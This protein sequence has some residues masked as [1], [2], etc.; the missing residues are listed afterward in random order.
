[1]P[2][3]QTNNDVY[4][5]AKQLRRNVV[6]GI[7]IV[8][9]IFTAVFAYNQHKNV[10][11]NQERLDNRMA[12]VK[13]VNAE[14]KKIE[15]AN[16]ELQKEVGIY[17]TLES[18][19]DFYNNFFN[20]SS[21]TQYRDNMK[22]LRLTYPNIDDD[23]VVDISG[24][25]IGASSSPTSSYDRE[26]FVGE[27][28]GETGEFVKQTKLYDDGSESSAIWYIISDYKDGKLDIKSMKAYRE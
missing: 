9:L 21:W 2:N 27:N 25:S 15:K 1:M 14:N 20:W 18:T 4:E 24:D 19:K 16:I 23:K 7:L 3:N 6:F 13:K 5:Q 12:E 17:D 28:K 8:I 26:T 22:Q 10:K 11:K